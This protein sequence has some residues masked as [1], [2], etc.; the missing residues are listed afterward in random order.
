MAALTASRHKGIMELTGWDTRMVQVKV[1]DVVADDGN[2]NDDHEWGKG[3]V[4]W[5]NLRFFQARA[6]LD[7]GSKV[8]DSIQVSLNPWRDTGTLAFGNCR[9]CNTPR[10]PLNSR[11]S[12]GLHRD[13]P[14]KSAKAL[15][16]FFKKTEKF[17][18]GEFQNEC[19]QGMMDVDRMLMNQLIIKFP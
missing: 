15:R 1:I 2:G 4:L 18:H 6:I 11:E 19:H 9:N 14:V 10:R 5:K 7:L 3:W 12:L 17:F 8:N 16:T 13:R